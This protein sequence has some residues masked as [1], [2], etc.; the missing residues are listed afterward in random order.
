M[1]KDCNNMS[2]ADFLNYAAQF[3]K[4]AAAGLLLLCGPDGF[5][6]DYDGYQDLMYFLSD[7]KEGK[8]LNLK[9][10]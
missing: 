10:E 4:E 9:E 1:M 2:R 6:E 8:P 5:N 3:G 7:G